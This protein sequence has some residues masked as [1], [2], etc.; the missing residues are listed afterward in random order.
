MVQLEVEVEEGVWKPVVRYDT[1]HGF[2]HRDIMMPDGS[3][4]KGP[5]DLNDFG[6]A[7]NFAQEDLLR[8]WM[9]Y[10]ENYLRRLT[11]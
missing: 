3:Q 1:S 7:L 4:K 5:F 8:S 10:R 9:N 2:A 6:S 11:T